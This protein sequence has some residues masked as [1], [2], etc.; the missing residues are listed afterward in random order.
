MIKKIFNIDNETLKLK[1]F[2]MYRYIMLDQLKKDCEDMGYSK[3]E[4]QEF[5]RDFL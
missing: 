5:E 3:R 4:I 2:L 1:K